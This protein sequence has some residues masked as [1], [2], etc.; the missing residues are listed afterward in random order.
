MSGLKKGDIV[1]VFGATGFV[2]RH[3]VQALAEKGFRIRAAVRRPDLAGH[4]QPM[5][6]PGQIMPIQ[7]NL[8]FP[9]SIEFALAGAEAAVNLV[10][11]L[12]ERGSQSFDAV[13]VEGPARIAEFADPFHP[14]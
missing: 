13:H 9:Q 6:G 1:T 12:E 8:R 3:V 7:A 10:G 14:C 11:I 5:G 4:L 2:G